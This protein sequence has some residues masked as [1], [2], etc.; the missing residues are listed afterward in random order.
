MRRREF[1]GLL[2]GAAV[3]PTSFDRLAAGLAA[4]LAHPSGNGLTLFPEEL[5]GN[6]VQLFKEAE[7]PTPV[8]VRA[9]EGIE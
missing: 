6:C 7:A 1:T 5:S 3:A 9:D 8:L 2:G 4:S